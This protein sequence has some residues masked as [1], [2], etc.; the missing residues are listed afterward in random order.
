M[1]DPV[2]T[3]RYDSHLRRSQAD[4]TRRA[5]LGAAR[6]LFTTQGYAET[7][8][9]DIAR[10][11]NVSVDTIYVSVG[12]K[13]QLLLAVHDMILGSSEDPLPAEQRD[14]VRRIRETA[15]AEDKV[16]LYARAL[17]RVLPGTAPLDLAL[18]EAARSEP[19]CRD[20]RESISARR[21]DNMVLF[22]ADLRRTG[23]LRD[24]LTDEQV[25]DLVWSM[26]SPEYFRLLTDAGY[27]P[28]RYAQL[29]ADVW[30]R[31]LL[32]PAG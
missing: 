32:T 19:D 10:V 16:R 30:I 7:A 17:A 12:R 25:A 11:A 13:P 9:A 2:K 22:A 28:G 4:A 26:N 29:V 21:R 23:R 14:Y 15:E 6:T 31:A 8:V 18:A 1:P 3:R 5:V 20:L 27:A 24:D